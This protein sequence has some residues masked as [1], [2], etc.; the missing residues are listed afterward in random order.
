MRELSGLGHEVYVITSGDGSLFFR[1]KEFP[2]YIANE[3][4]FEWGNTG[5]S[6][7]RTLAKSVESGVTL[8]RHYMVERDIIRRLS[9]DIVVV[10][11][12]GAPVV[13]ARQ[14]EL[15]SILITNQLSV[16]SGIGG[17]DKLIASYMP[18]F[19]S[20]ADRILVPDLPPPYTI[21][22]RNNV[23]PLRLN[24]SLRDKVVF[25]GPILNFRGDLY[26]D[27]ND[28]SGR[29]YDVFIFISA[30]SLDRKF[31]SIRMIDVARRLS[32]TYRTIISVGEP[33]FKGF[34]SVKG[35]L[36]IRGWVT[37][38]FA[39]LGDSKVVVLRGGQ[40]AIMES[41][42]TLTPMIIIPA[43]NQTE[44][45]ENARRV[46]ELGIGEFVDPAVFYDDMDIL[47]DVITRVMDSY[48]RYVDRLRLVRN[49]LLSSG[50]V[51]KAVEVVLGALNLKKGFR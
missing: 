3:F 32:E 18:R 19:W 28:F 38:P 10:D 9:P 44:Q 42:I 27:V 11:S 45:L 15:P 49:V 33:T 40:T 1:D 26:L 36:E 4:D 12:R 14:Y 2:V 24:P 20:L 17:V 46:K 13:V 5:L 51:E 47:F 22:Y 30:P 25:I 6:L 21:T 37:D 29:R 43:L 34:R 16:M 8:Y 41:I 39:M 35:G 23:Y 50:G 48:E 7:K 31:L